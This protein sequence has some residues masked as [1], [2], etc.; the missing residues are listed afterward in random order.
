MAN[1]TNCGAALTA[2][3]TFCPQCGAQLPDDLFGAPA[4]VDPATAPPPTDGPATMAPPPQ[5][6]PGMQSQTYGGSAGGNVASGIPYADDFDDGPAPNTG[7]A[8]GLAIFAT[9]CCCLPGGIAGI[10][11]ANQARQA[12]QAGDYDSARAKLKTAYVIIGVSIALGAVINI[13][14]LAGSS[15]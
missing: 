14:Y 1:C 15:M 8:L 11:M 13:F 12:V 9:L 4:A 2:P 5:A 6:D 10:V 3:T 7:A